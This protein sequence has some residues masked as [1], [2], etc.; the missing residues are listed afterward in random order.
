ME[1]TNDLILAYTN[2]KFH[3][4]IPAII[5]EIGKRNEDLDSLIK[6][7][8]QVEW[9]Y[10]TAYNPYSKE[11]TDKENLKR[12]SQLLSKI[13]DYKFYEGEGVGEDPTWKPERSIL[14]VG[15]PKNEAIS[16]GR[17]FEQNAIVYGKINEVPELIILN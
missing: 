12:Q 13:S 2:T 6:G 1:I 10:L 15:I 16:S 5:I 3:V 11:L 8:E 14:I 17:E 4:F 7:D 9:A